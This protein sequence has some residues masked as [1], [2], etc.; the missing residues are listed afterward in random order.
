VLKLSPKF[1]RFNFF[2][3]EMIK[4][5]KIISII[6]LKGGCGRSTLA[7]NLA[8]ELAK[9][10]STLLFDCDVPQCTSAS[11]YALRDRSDRSKNLTIDTASTH[12][13]LI[14]KLSNCLDAE[15]L[16]IDSPPRLAEMARAMIVV[17]DLVLIPIATSAAEIWATSD[18]MNLVEE[19]KK[20]RPIEARMV[21]ARHRENTRLAKELVEEIKN[22][23]TIPLLKTSMG[24]RVAYQEAL[25]LGLTGTE[26][27]DRTAKKEVI[28]LVDEIKKILNSQSKSIN[29]KTLS[30]GKDK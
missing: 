1:A 5:Q 20:V 27:G 11:W 26:T 7:T 13:E 29:K 6:N 19:A 24:L 8:G 2:E 12:Q 23:L 30:K 15:F 9:T 10:A 3:I 18:M 22:V 21:W 16:I 14:E 28:N 17:S 4:K 25:G